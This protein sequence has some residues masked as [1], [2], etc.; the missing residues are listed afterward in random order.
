M[1]MSDQA[2]ELQ[3]FSPLTLF[4]ADHDTGTHFK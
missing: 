1:K 2:I 3:G 4:E